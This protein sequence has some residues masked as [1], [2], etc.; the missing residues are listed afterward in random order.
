MILDLN[1]KQFSPLRNSEGGRVASDAVFI[2]A[3]TG[4]AF[5][6]TY[7]GEGFSDGHLIGQMRGDMTAT[8]IYHCRS[9]DGSLEAGEAEAIF[10][11]DEAG[12]LT[13]SMNW[14]WLNGSQQSGSSYY[15]ERT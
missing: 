11:R 12:K 7:S 1:G 2:F 9:E 14:R 15:G 13:I 4:D 8:L 6:A 10:E 5:T 3:Q